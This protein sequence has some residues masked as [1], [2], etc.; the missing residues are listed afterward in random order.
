[1]HSRQLDRV[2]RIPG[3]YRDHPRPEGP[4]RQTGKSLIQDFPQIVWMQRPK[5]QPVPPPR[6]HDLVKPKGRATACCA[7][8]GQQAEADAVQ[9]PQRERQ[10]TCG[11]RVEPLHVI[12]GDQHRRLDDQPPQYTDHGAA[13]RVR[14]HKLPRRIGSKQRDLQGAP[15]RRRQRARRRAGPLAEQIGKA[16]IC[17]PGLRLGTSHPQDA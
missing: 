3:R 12:N 8:C 6:R 15:L 7:A 14:F 9:P 1:V 11:R 10:R 2:Q 4:P 13:H 17:Q 5:H 16:G